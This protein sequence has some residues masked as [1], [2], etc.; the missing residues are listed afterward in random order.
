MILPRAMSHVAIT[1]PDIDA[2]FAWYRDV[3]GCYVIANPSEADDD[4][5][6]LGNVVK[7]IF[8]EEF[9]GLKLAHLS[10]ADG[11]GIE[12]FQFIKPKTYVPDNTFD[13]ARTGIFHICIIDRP[14]I[15]EP[16]L[17]H[18][19]RQAFNILDCH[20]GQLF[21][22][23]HSGMSFQIEP[24]FECYTISRTNRPPS[25]SDLHVPIKPFAHGI[26]LDVVIPAAE[27]KG[28]RF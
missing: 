20:L 8:G 15:E 24:Y 27:G 22:R 5:S 16:S 18:R 13:Y 23:V 11:V 10:T 21:N 3:L 17:S 28:T 26:D 6:N 12:L 4:D 25:A 19:C 9:G 7:D 2:A 14:K 1:V